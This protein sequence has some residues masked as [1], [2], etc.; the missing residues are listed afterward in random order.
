MKLVSKHFAKE[1][2]I[3]FYA[4]SLCISIKHLTRVIKEMIGKTPHTVICD[5]IT[6][7][8]MTLLEDDSI[9][10]GEIAETLHLSDQASFCK[11]FKKQKKISPMAYRRQNKMNIS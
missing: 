8:A 10:I 11:F 2:H 5:E 4:D 9:S 3:E 7:Q 6:H 1:H